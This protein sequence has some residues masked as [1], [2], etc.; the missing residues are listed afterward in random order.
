MFEKLF[1]YSADQYASGVIQFDA[2]LLRIALVVIAALALIMFTIYMSRT[3]QQSRTR[4]VT[5]S[6]RTLVILLVLLP[7]L[8]PSLVVPDVVPDE[9]FVA[10]V[11]DASE[12]MGISDG[13]GGVSRL[14]NAASIL[15]DDESGIVS[16]L[17]DH[18]QVRYYVFDEKASR[19]D[20]ISHAQA[21][22]STTS[23][24]SALDKVRSDFSGVPLSGVVVVSDGGDNGKA[25]PINVAEQMGASDI[26]LHVIGVGQE[27]F[28][29]ER[30]ILEVNVDKAIE[31]NTGAEIDVKVRSWNDEIR[32]VDFVIYQGSEEVFRESRS[33]KGK[34]K[35]DQFSFFF[36]PAQSG[37]AEYV[38]EI[39]EAEGEINVENNRLEMLIDMENDTTRVLY[40]EGALRPDFKFIKRALEDD[41]VVEFVSVSRTGTGKYFRQGVRTAD[42]LAG[43][44]PLTEAE[45][46]E[47]KAIMLGDIEAS[48]FSVE[49]QL[50]LEK[51]VRVRGGGFLMLGGQSAFV[52]GGYWGTPIADILP[53][54][55]DPQRRQSVPV[56]FS[57]QDIVPEAQGF[58]FHPT[59]AGI[60]SPILKLS[61]DTRTNAL[62]WSSMPGL[63][64]INYVGAAKPGAQVLAVKQSD[65][66]GAEEPLLVSQR[67]GRG[68]SIALPTSST[69]RWQMLSDAKDTRHERFWRQLVRWLA[70][71]APDQ[72]NISLSD[73][74]P[75]P[76]TEVTVTAVA[77]DDEFQPYS[78]A[79]IKGFLRDPFGTETEIVF[80]EDLTTDGSYSTNLLP[81]DEGVYH[82]AI[83]AMDGSQLIGVESSSFLVRK[84]R[85]EF[86]DATM[87]R[88]LLESIA[89]ASGG[90]YHA[91]SEANRIPDR[92]RT[93]R[94]S[95]TVYESGT[96][97]DLPILFL[98][99][100][101]LLSFD[102]YYRRKN[103]LR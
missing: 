101:G 74:Y 40:F 20:S 51:F 15:L 49:Q 75:E 24:A 21:N 62:R 57:R 53:V 81:A 9:N 73:E 3:I 61:S 17:E 68:R 16:D 55:L 12:S 54:S 70:A 25:L 95:T 13:E 23:L 4:W 69:W 33:L 29:S 41:Q 18:F 28:A 67:Y 44:F 92:L 58:K 34:G 97:W 46:F 10:V 90:E 91:P 87:K 83:S 1:K 36:E 8:R 60:D 76:E 47:Y 6:L 35:I 96:L 94:T 100:I 14:E 78:G 64:S 52:E 5:V 37:I 102:W 27:S 63:T 98:F 30:E 85:K 31:E 84:S 43:G 22:G 86:K 38:L 42:E 26:P 39:V 48:N 103:G 59:L 80:T 89:T 11:V 50:L 7:F 77:Y 32:P 45:I 56:V 82:L 99:L 79:S 65:A 88:S 66:F 71:S 19:T 72:L 2:G 93:R